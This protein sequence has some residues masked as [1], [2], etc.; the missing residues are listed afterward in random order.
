MFRCWKLLISLILAMGG[1]LFTQPRAQAS[2][3]GLTYQGRI[4]KADGGP[5]EYDKVSFL[6]QILDPSGTCL[7]YQEQLSN[8]NMAN[9]RGV[10]DVPIGEGSVQFP[11][12]GGTTILDAFNNSSVFTCGTCSVLGSFY[13]CSNSASTYTPVVG[14]GRKLRVSFYDGSGWKAIS[15]DN[16]IRS[17][18]FSAFAQSAQ[19]L[20]DK[21]ATDFLTKAGLPSC[22]PN[23]FLSW[24]SGSSSMTCA[25]VAGASLAGDVTG[26]MSANKVVALQNQPVD[27]TTPSANQVL[28]WDGAKWAPTTLEAGNPGTITA[29][30]GDV[31]AS[32]TGSVSATINSVGGSTAANIHTAELAANAATNTDTASTIVKRDASGNFSAGTITATF[33]GN[34]TGAAS[35]NVQKTGDAMSGDLSFAAGKGAI[36]TAGS[37]ANTITIAGPTGAVGAS[38]VLKLPTDVA[39]VNGQV[40]TSDT[41]GNLTWTTPTTTATSYS[42]VLP[43]ANGGTNSATAL[44]N[45]RIMVSNGD[46]IVESAALGN[47]QLLV[48]STGAAPIPATLSAGAGI[49]ITNGAG[50]ITIATTSVGLPSGTS[51]G[52]PYYISG[53]TIGSSAALTANGVVL[54][55]GAGVTPTSTA[56]G[57]AYQVLR[58]PAGGGSPEFGSI[59]ISQAPAITG[60][61]GIINGG[62]GATTDVGARTN[63]GLGTTATKDTGTVSGNVPLVGTSGISS[64]KMCTSD[65]SGNL[66][67]N[68]NIPTSSQWNTTGSDIYYN[69]GKVGVGTASPATALDVDGVATFRQAYFERVG[70]LGALSCGVTNITGFTTNLYTLTACASG[71]TTLNI[72]TIT[73]WPSGSMSWTVTFFVT[74]QANS[75][76]NVNYNGATT[77]VYWDK[78][79]TGGS[80]GASYSGFLVNSGSTS[81]ISCAVL[82]TGS[83]AVYCGVAAQ[84]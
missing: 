71:T 45:N 70:A 5:L 18:P 49:N 30:T 83:V 81:V 75:L 53:T 38:Y 39:S 43:V 20:G 73:G 65:G 15:T 40:L 32:G 23:T 67:C 17:V 16:I 41:L 2:P 82:N 51:G 63:L 12:G 36:F 9:S 58:V 84:Y 10:F 27:A 76:F 80:G 42:G 26:S 59:D 35:F 46:A 79:S 68:T 19:K 50:S 66:I 7:I 29:L 69:V 4:L 3:A 6:F 72:P 48:G 57:T 78:N 25:G 31:S 8:I 22:G 28:Q 74:G 11:T 24:D 56:A 60:A 1:F 77:A 37:G 44:S 55:G 52:I 21:V 13:S 64:N 62:T 33:V 14:D 61:L 47:G 54:G 34:V